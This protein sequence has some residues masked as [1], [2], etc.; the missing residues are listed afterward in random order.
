MQR[1]IKQNFFRIAK[2]SP[3][4]RLFFLHSTRFSFLWF[5]FATASFSAF[6][7]SPAIFSLERMFRDLLT[8]LISERNL[9][10]AEYHQSIRFQSFWG[11]HSS[12]E[13]EETNRAGKTESGGQVGG[14]QVKR[15]QWSRLR[16]RPRQSRNKIG[17]DL[18]HARSW[19]GWWSWESR[20]IWWSWVGQGSLTAQGNREGWKGSKRSRKSIK[21]RGGGENSWKLARRCVWL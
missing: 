3:F 5:V 18:Q 16:G 2:K 11:C 17:R 15:T 13:N 14:T 10:P 19:G 9:Y 4:L 6:C 8:T 1:K 7:T 12:F 21:L 20:G